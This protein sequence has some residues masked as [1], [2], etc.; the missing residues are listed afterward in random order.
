ML[1]LNINLVSK[2]WLVVGGGK[3]A[4]RRVKKILDEMGKVKLVSPK[5]TKT[6]ARLEEKNKNL[7]IIKRKFKKSDIGK[8]DFI[9]ACTDDKKINKDIVTYAKSKKIFVCN[10]SNKEDNDF[11][12]T[13]T[14]N[15]NKEIKIN[16][17][18]NGKNASL[19]KLIRIT[20]EKN[21]KKKILDLYKK[22]K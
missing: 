15:V 6:L 19:T 2:K 12:F 11:S 13:S 5:I 10:A 3:V 9:L 4:T 8:Q 20:L 7:K 21:L 16:F 22:V 14:I 17:S 1:N 18:T